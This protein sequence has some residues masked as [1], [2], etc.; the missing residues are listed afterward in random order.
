MNIFRIIVFTST[1]PLD[2]VIWNNIPIPEKQV[3]F[4]IFFIVYS[5]HQIPDETFE[6][7]HSLEW[8][9]LW[10]NELEGM[11]YSLMEPVLDTLK[12]LDIHSKLNLIRTRN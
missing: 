8:L 11:S 7:L 1:F 5:I 4:L 6:D 9:K 12:H 3:S 2:V 10:N